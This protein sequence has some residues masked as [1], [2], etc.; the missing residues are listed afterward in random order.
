MVGGTGRE[1]MEVVREGG[2]KGQEVGGREG[3]WEG[4]GE[5]V[6]EVVREG[7]GKGQE[8]G[9]REGWW[10]GLGEEGLR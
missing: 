10:E 7:G 1:G 2:G 4:L 3:W 8:V 5:K 9:G 6:V